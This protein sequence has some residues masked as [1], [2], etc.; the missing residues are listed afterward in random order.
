MESIVLFFLLF[1]NSFQDLSFLLTLTYNAFASKI[2]ELS[3]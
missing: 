3:G 2:E 1:F